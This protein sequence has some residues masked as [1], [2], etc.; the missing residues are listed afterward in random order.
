MS[1]QRDIMI[2]RAASRVT[3]GLVEAVGCA[4][5]EG[6]P[7]DVATTPI[8]EQTRMRAASA[9]DVLCMTGQSS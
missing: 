8:G 7:D 6:L 1:G 2:D 3:T 4:D 9:A 5:G